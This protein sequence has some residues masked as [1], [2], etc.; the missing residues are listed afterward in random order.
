VLVIFD[1]PCDA[2]NAVTQLTREMVKAGL[3]IAHAG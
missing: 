1:S 3:P 2:V